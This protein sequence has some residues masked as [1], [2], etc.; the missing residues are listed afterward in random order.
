MSSR[1]EQHDEMEALYAEMQ[2]LFGSGADAY[3]ATIFEGVQ[4][5]YLAVMPNDATSPPGKD[6]SQAEV[7][8]PKVKGK[9]PHPGKYMMPAERDVAAGPTPHCYIE[10]GLDFHDP[11]NPYYK[12]KDVSKYSMLQML[13]TIM[14]TGALSSVVYVYTC[15]CMCPCAHPHVPLLQLL[16]VPI[17]ALLARVVCTLAF[18]HNATRATHTLVCAPQRIHSNVLLCGVCVCVCVCVCVTRADFKSLYR[19]DGYYIIPAA[20]TTKAAATQLQWYVDQL[21]EEGRRFE[22]CP[23]QCQIAMYCFWVSALWNAALS[24]LQL[25]AYCVMGKA[26]D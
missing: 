8:V 21:L 11:N 22:A 19:E 14:M 20:P 10:H 17:S 2:D 6:L 24:M 1:T 23:W 12:H 4:T 5:R 15:L 26:I 16:C 13:D 18:L 3:F 9:P 7:A 25:Q